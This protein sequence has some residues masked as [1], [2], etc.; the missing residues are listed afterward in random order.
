[1]AVLA[2]LFSAAVCTAQAIDTEIPIP[3]RLRGPQ[4]SAYLVVGARLA[5][6]LGLIEIEAQP[7]LEALDGAITPTALDAVREL[8]Q[9]GW[10][11]PAE[12]ASREFDLRFDPGD[13]AAEL[14]IPVIALGT[15][16][17]SVQQ[18]RSLPDL[19][20]APVAD[21]AVSIPLWA[22]YGEIHASGVGAVREVTVFSYPGIRA[23]SW[24]LESE[25]LAQWRDGERSEE[26]E[27][28]RIVR[29]WQESSLRLQAGQ[30]FQF[31]RGLAPAEPVIGVSLDNLQRDTSRAVVPVLL[32]RPLIVDT[33]G[34]I[35]V[36]VNGRQVRS[37]P[38]QPG[39]YLVENFPVA[40]GINSVR[41]AYTRDD[42]A[43]EEYELIV[44]HS[45]GVLRDG[46]LQYAVAAGVEQDAPERPTGLGFL[47]YGLS[48]SLTGGLILDA[49]GRGTL[50]GVEATGA[51]DFGE[52]SLELYGSVDDESVL[53]W[54]ARGGYRYNVLGRLELPVFATSL[55]YRSSRFSRPGP[56]RSATRQAWQ[57][58]SS[59]SQALPLGL[60]AV[61]GH[62][63]RSY[64][65]DTPDSSL[66]YA[67]IGR[68]LGRR[69]S[70]RMTGFVDFADPDDQWGL[71]ITV[72]GQAVRRRVG[73]TAVVDARTSESDLS[74]NGSRAGSTTV[75]GTAAVRDLALDDGTL[76]AATANLRASHHRFD[77][78]ANGALSFAEE[79][80]LPAPEVD[81]SS[82]TIQAGAGA[83]YA[84]GAF[85]VAAP[86]RTAF[87]LVRP[88]SGLPTRRV[89][90]DTGGGSGRT[91]RSGPLGAAVVAPLQN[92]Q[93]EPVTVEVPDVPADYSLGST[94]FIVSP[95]YRSGTAI[96]IEALQRLY[97]RGRL[98]DTDGA[99]VAYVMLSVEPQFDPGPVAG[100]RPIGGLA[101]T[102]EQGVFDLYDLIPGA[103]RLM[104]GDG[105]GRFFTITVP[106]QPG[107]LVSLGEVTPSQGETR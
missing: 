61:V 47:R 67:T 1:M 7:V 98:V 9:D 62:V 63:Y 36:F 24:V 51:L 86:H 101:F 84:D 85:A 58:T 12:L 104:V 55:E 29:T 34:T 72:V 17:L 16:V 96:T 22:R 68:S 42:G 92:G 97:A 50:G 57:A 43:T 15:Q 75:S 93:P 8:A 91:V 79:G 26:I 14:E 107:P 66:L 64:H 49:S 35:D 102:D 70:G 76:Q 11:S 20:A 88:G 60:G 105:S 77:V 18:T 69:F 95:R 94:G 2:F 106:D 4:T 25:L 82:Y 5:P 37:F 89:F 71:S 87:A 78:T 52:P 31:S 23:R 90:V 65:D 59:V 45:G 54:A 99:P 6:D 10:L 33:P 32:D 28:T 30:V 27:N 80:A 103:Y 3:L 39:R 46:A 56:S 81:R 13:L 74:I 73:A 48:P 83:Y 19:P 53:G 41:V 38:V 21:L 40:A 100:E 44:P